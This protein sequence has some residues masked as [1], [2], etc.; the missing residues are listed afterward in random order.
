MRLDVFHWY[1]GD[2]FETMDLVRDRFPDKNLSFRKVVW[3]T[4]SLKNQIPIAL[5]ENGQIATITVL[6]KS[7]A[8][9]SIK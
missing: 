4:A 6:P 2:Y 1:S 5:R 3:N 9:C 8:T 7:V